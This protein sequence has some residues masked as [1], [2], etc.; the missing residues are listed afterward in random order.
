MDNHI[1]VGADARVRINF[2]RLVHVNR[3]N[4]VCFAERAVQSPG[5]DYFGLPVLRLK[6]AL[7][8]YPRAKIFIADDYPLKSATQQYL[9]VLGVAKTDIV[10]FE[11]FEYC[12]G[13]FWTRTFFTIYAQNILPCSEERFFDYSMR[14]SSDPAETLS[15]FFES[16]ENLKSDM[17]GNRTVPECC[18]NC[19]NLVTGV[20]PKKITIR[21]VGY[22]VGQD[23][24]SACVYCARKFS[25][26]G[27]RSSPA[28]KKWQNEFDFP[29]FLD[30][31]KKTEY[32]DEKLTQIF[33]GPGEITVHRNR[34]A[35]LAAALADETQFIVA[36]NGFLFDGGVAALAAKP[37]NH[38]F[39]SLD[40]GTP[41]TFKLVKQVGKFEQTLDNIRRYAESGSKIYLKYIVLPQNSNGADLKG[42]LEFAH[43]I[44]PIGVDVSVDAFMPEKSITDEMRRFAGELAQGLE[45]AGIPYLLPAVFA[46]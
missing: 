44:C 16:V 38:L 19:R 36:S 37:Q 10:N 23:C 2:N 12:R 15:L 3:L 6:E 17:A 9:L 22:G 4:P 35:I 27:E 25:E 31:F 28:V 29:R 20:H 18:F 13:C 46:R 30:E 26:R 5:G 42:F 34:E 43:S 33:L 8:A 32:Y 11:E 45:S 24:N 21:Q 7:A 14:C 39:I 40:A 1:L 41:E